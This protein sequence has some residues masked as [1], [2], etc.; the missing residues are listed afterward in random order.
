MK[1]RWKV[2]VVIMA[3]LIRTRWKWGELNLVLL[4]RCC[5]GYCRQ[6]EDKLENWAALSY[7]ALHTATP[8]CMKRF[9]QWTYR[10]KTSLQRAWFGFKMTTEICISV[11][12]HL[13]SWVYILL[14]EE[15][16][17]YTFNTASGG[18]VVTW[19]PVSMATL[20]DSCGCRH[21]A[22]ACSSTSHSV[23]E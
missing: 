9:T 23:S 17:K 3:G 20:I 22:T 6:A 18:R 4:S 5:K 19:S 14:N 1:D 7:S 10:C 2:K 15:L 8:C 21:S 11:V 16:W 12:L 13:L